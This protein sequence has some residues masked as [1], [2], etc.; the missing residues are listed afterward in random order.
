M[1]G[2][3]VLIWHVWSFGVCPAFGLATCRSLDIGHR[4][5]TIPVGRGRSW[6]FSA[7]ARA[8]TL[9]L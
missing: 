7:R 1:R 6:V 8:S 9:R 4:S 3:D 2:D 5:T